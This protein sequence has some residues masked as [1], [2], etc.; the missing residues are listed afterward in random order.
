MR[1]KK[2]YQRDREAVSPGIAIILM[3]VIIIVLAGVLWLRVSGLVDTGKDEAIG[4]IVNVEPDTRTVNKDYVLKVEIL[5]SEN[6]LS[7]EGFRFTL[8]STDRRDMSNGQHRVSNVYGKP[9]D[10]SRPSSAS[11]TG[12]TTASCPSATGSS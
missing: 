3:V 11:V 10:E 5:N 6:C 4:G 2:G 8:Y 12:I 9:I 7:V 1:R